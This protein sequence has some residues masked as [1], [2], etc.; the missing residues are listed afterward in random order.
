MQTGSAVKVSDFDLRHEFQLNMRNQNGGVSNRNPEENTTDE[1]KSKDNRPQVDPKEFTKL[2]L[3]N[4]GEYRFKDQ[5]IL[6]T[7]RGSGFIRKLSHNPHMNDPISTF[8]GTTVKTG[9]NVFGDNLTKDHLTN[10][11]KNS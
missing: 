7:E 4:C 2:V 3:Q 1:E 5:K 8:Y 10:V 6:T 11:M 9:R